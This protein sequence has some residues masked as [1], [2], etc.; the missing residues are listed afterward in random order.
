[1]PTKPSDREVVAALSKKIGKDLDKV[2]Y[3]KAGNLISLDLS[4]LGLSQLPPEIGQLTNLQT[5]DLRKNQLTQLPPEIGRLTNLHELH[6]S[7]NQ[8]VQ[9]PPEVWQL[10]NLSEL[11]LYHIPL[12]QLPE[13]W[14]LTNL[15]KLVLDGTLLTQL[16]PEIG[17]LTNLSELWLHSC[18]LTRLPP[19]IGRL[20]NLK[21]IQ[22]YGNQ[23]ALLPPEIGQMTN[24]HELLLNENQLTHLPPE[25]GRLTN[26]ERLALSSNQLS[27]LPLEIGRLTKLG[28]LEVTDN[29]NLHTPPPEIVTRGTSDMLSFLRELQERSTIRYEAK[30]LLVGEGGTGKSSLLRALRDEKFVSNLSTTHGIEVGKLK[31]PHPNRPQMEI[32]LNTWDFGGQQIYHAT[33]QFFLTK[34]SLYLVVWNARLGAEQGRLD[35]WLHTIKIL[36]P[37]APVLL[38]ATH[39]DERAPDLNYQL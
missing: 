33:H 35:H 37:D 2:E 25:I 14:Q 18:H 7:E 8:F 6:L 16:P 11:W 13:V 26:L 10:T 15:Q 5:L 39:I 29:P 3:D 9:L 22:L 38:V 34:R 24:L 19:E 21:L 36:A 32:T 20:T 23:L 4:D 17:Q 31:L 30:L 12:T 28:L 1:M 27:Q